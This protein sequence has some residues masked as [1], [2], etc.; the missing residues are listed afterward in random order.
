MLEVEEVKQN[1]DAHHLT[2]DER[3]ITRLFRSAAVNRMRLDPCKALSLYEF[4]IFSKKAGE[5]FRQLM[6]R[7]KANML[8]D[9]VRKGTSTV[10]CGKRGGEA[11]RILPQRNDKYIE[12]LP[13]SFNPLMNHFKDEEK[14]GDLREK[15]T[16]TLRQITAL[17][18]DKRLDC[19]LSD[20]AETMRQL[21]ASHFTRGETG[22]QER[23]LFSQTRRGPEM[24]E[25]QQAVS[26]ARTACGGMR[27]RAI[28]P[29]VDELVRKELPEVE[30]ADQE[31]M[32]YTRDIRARSQ[33]EIRDLIATARKGTTT[34][35]Q[36]TIE[37]RKEARNVAA[38]TQDMN[39]TRSIT[40]AAARSTSTLKHA[41]STSELRNKRL[42]NEHL[43]LRANLGL[44]GSIERFRANPP[45][46]EHMS[47]TLPSMKFKARTN[48][49]DSAHSEQKTLGTSRVYAGML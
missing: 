26:K 1:F 16:E 33:R 6:D 18:Q 4:G 38:L 47:R 35:S 19:I 21:L 46:D 28:P 23:K 25:Y 30:R 40:S 27:R 34:N 15:M 2:V 5:D 11:E 14:R 45:A 29:D 37:G 44:T 36:P 48:V 9:M 8:R 10:D 41:A 31:E 22:D 39:R 13:S 32:A 3:S 42:L 43:V 7:I 24:A 20:S 12:Y 17:G 49:W